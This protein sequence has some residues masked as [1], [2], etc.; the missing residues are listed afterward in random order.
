MVDFNDE[1]TELESNNLNTLFELLEYT[2]AL[3]KEVNRLN[4]KIRHDKILSVLNRIPSK[5]ILYDSK[6][7]KK[8]NH[9]NKETNSDKIIIR[10]NE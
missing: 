5:T 9:N 1:N 6:S 7:Y 2:K 4:K 8:K 3:Y 10:F